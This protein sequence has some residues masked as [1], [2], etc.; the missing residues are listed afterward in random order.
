[1]LVS[2]PLIS[3]IHF[4]QPAVVGPDYYATGF[5]GFGDGKVCASGFEL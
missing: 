2:L 4:S 1:M 5:A 3:A